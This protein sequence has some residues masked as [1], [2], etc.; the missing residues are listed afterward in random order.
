MYPEACSDFLIATLI[1]RQGLRS[2]Y[3]G[4]AICFEQTNKNSEKEFRMRV[5]VIAQTF[6]DLWRNR[7]MMNPLK[8]GFYA[9]QLFSHKVG[10][11]SV[12]FL[13][14]L[15]F[16]SSIAL[17][18]SSTVFAVIVLLQVAF[19]FAAALGWLLDR[20]GISNSI[21]PI[22]FYFVLGNIATMAGFISF[23]RGERYVNWEPARDTR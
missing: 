10:R 23:L 3:E 21:L 14:I 13:L 18:P 15:I 20:N 12:P 4:D 9:I 5:R 1:Y 17:A 8:S 2:V 11:Y 22:P 16:L 7:D 6:G 19:Y